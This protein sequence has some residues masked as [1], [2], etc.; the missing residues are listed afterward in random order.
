MKPNYLLLCGL[1]FLLWGATGC[2]KKYQNVS[3][4]S[5]PA[6]VIEPPVSQNQP[7][8]VT[9]RPGERVSQQPAPRPIV[10][11]TAPESTTPVQEEVFNIAFEPKET[12]HVR[13]VDYDPFGGVSELAIDLDRLSADF[14]YP[15]PGNRISNYGMRNGAMHAGV[16]IKATPNDTVRAALSGV[17]RMS[18]LYSGYGNIVVIR[19]PCGVETAYAHNTKNLVRPN[20][21]VRG[22]DPIA[23]AG[24]TGR[25]TTEHVHFETRVMGEHFDPNLLIDTQNHTLKSGTLYLTRQSGRI[26]ASA[27]PGGYMAPQPSV[28]GDIPGR[29]TVH[30]GDTLYSIS[31]TYGVTI[32]QLCRINGISPD[33]I[34]SIGQQLK[35]Q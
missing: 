17:V 15:Y 18:K 14:H 26:Y 33:G 22:G 19:H 21:L 2:T 16:D 5:G 11:K 7:E 9:A 32:D 25:A 1:F 8:F 13:I 3:L 35:I 28:S 20:D 34:L 30:R 10:P 4:V 6:R 29:Y 12:E 23:L 27:T 31:R 24:R